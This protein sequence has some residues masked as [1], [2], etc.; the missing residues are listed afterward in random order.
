MI[1]DK[2]NRSLLFI[3]RMETIIVQEG[4]KFMNTHEKSDFKTK[5]KSD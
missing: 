3:E 5:T 4:K 1:A 2:E